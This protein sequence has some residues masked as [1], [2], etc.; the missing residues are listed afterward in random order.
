MVTLTLSTESLKTLALTI[1]DIDSKWGYSLDNDLGNLAIK[2]FLGRWR[3]Q[4]GKAPRHWLVSELGKSTT[5]HL[6][7]HGIIW[8]DKPKR[9]TDLWAY[10]FTWIGSYVG[11]RTANYCV[12]YILKPDPK[13]PNYRP[14]L[15]TSKGIGKNYLQSRD[16]QNAK[17]NGKET[18]E[19]AT[20]RTGHKIYLPA[21]YRNKLYTD[22]QRE[23]LWI[24]KLDSEKRTVMGQTVSI[25]RN[26]AEY[27]HLLHSAQCKNE[28]LGFSPLNQRTHL[29]DA[30]NDERAQ[31]QKKRLDIPQPTD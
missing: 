7:F 30:E 1:K 20:T 28:R 13:H 15:Y 8:T 9:I 26:N 4:Y 16:A 19:Y 23:Q 14:K 27:L 6:H 2:R 17:Y 5:E 31:I 11:E 25:S 22:Q 24:E 3:K 21:Y 12:K 18:R 10:G 29:K